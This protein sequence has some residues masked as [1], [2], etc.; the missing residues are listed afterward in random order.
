MLHAVQMA[1]IFPDSK[2]FVDMPM[3]FEEATVL[4]K[5]QELLTVRML[6]QLPR[7]KTMQGEPILIKSYTRNVTLQSSGENELS[8]ED[9]Q[10]FVD[11]NFLPPGSEFADW[12]PSDWKDEVELFSNIKVTHLMVKLF[13]KR[14]STY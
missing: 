12:E 14:S 13:R 11:D 7:Q 4:E 8:K 2:T 9:L 6:A 10:K 3:K 1:R 5:Y